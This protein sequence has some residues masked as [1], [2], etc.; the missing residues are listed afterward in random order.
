ML[1][2]TDANKAS[3]SLEFEKQKAKKIISKDYF[4]YPYTSLSFT[5]KKQ[6]AAICLISEWRLYLFI[7]LLKKVDK[8]VYLLLL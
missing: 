2:T 5:D 3:P 7:L 4:Y 1:L 6:L 8:Y